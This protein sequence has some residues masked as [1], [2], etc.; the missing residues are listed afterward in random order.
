MTAKGG[1]T[2][3]GPEVPATDRGARPRVARGLLAGA[4]AL[5][6]AL[7]GAAVYAAVSPSA[8]PAATAPT[9]AA[10]GDA[11]AAHHALQARTTAISRR[12]LARR[13][14]IK[15]TLVGVTAAGGLVDLRFVI[16]D[17]AKARRLFTSQKVMP[18]V[19]DEGTGTVLQ[20]PHG[21]HHGHITPATGASY[22]V[23]MGNAGGAVQ[24][25]VPVSVLFNTVRV[26]HVTAES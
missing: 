23:L 19:V 13:Y 12:L 3:P 25:G 6:A 2:P 14:G 1:P 16:T 10:Y 24:R 21:G 4:M 15:L 7:G 17:A 26:E 8:P 11:H 18:A 20:P 22:F 5:A 9:A